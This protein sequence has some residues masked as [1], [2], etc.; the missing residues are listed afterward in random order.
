MLILSRKV[1]EKI[2]IG[3]QIEVVVK[4]ISGQRVTLGIEAPPSV[5]IVRG[6]LEPLPAP[7]PVPAADNPVPPL[8]LEI[9][10]HHFV[11]VKPR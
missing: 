8:H 5:H 2:V 11:P 1:G 7:A 6:E 3:E 9:D 10:P 4:R